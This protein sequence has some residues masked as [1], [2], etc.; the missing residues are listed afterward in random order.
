MLSLALLRSAPALRQAV[1][2]VPVRGGWSADEKLLVTLANGRRLLLRLAEAEK[3]A[4][5]RGE[6]A[7]LLRAAALGL[8]VPEP[9]ACGL[10]EADGRAYLVL[11]WIEGAPLEPLLPT[12]AP[13]A[14]Y[15][16]GLEAGRILRVL[17]TLPAPADAPAWSE[18]FCRKID[19]KFVLYTGCPLRFAGDDG[20]LACLAADRPLLAGRPQSMHHGDFHAGNLLP[21]IGRQAWRDRLRPLGL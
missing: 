16:C 17:H 3:L 12:L 4:R 10:L 18:R 6:H 1:S 7:L 21:C 5:K 2:A 9:V 13:G 19:R 14:Q 20:L 11:R 15:R 8:R